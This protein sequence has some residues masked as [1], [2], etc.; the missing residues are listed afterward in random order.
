MER[1]YYKFIDLEEFEAV[2][3]DCREGKKGRYEVVL[4][5]T[6]FFP[7]GGGQPGDTGVLGQAQVL[8]THEKNGEVVHETDRP[9]A[10]GE[11]VKGVLD[12]EKRFD[13]MQGHS[14]EHILTGLI[15]KTF[16]FDNVGFHMGKEE[17]T[18]DF[19]GTMTMEQLKELEIKANQV[20]YENVPFVITCPSQ[21]ELE[22]MEYRSKKELTGEV[23]IVTIPEVDVC[24]CCGTHVE[25]SGEVGLIK[26]LGMI[27]YK[28]GVRISM[29]CG[30]PAF[31][32]LDGLQ[33]QMNAMSVLLSAKIG[34][35]EETVEKL[36]AENAEKDAQV[37]RA[38]QEIFAARAAALPESSKPLV[39]FEEGLTPVQIRQFSTLL[40]ESNKG[41]VAVVCSKKG[42]SFQYAAGSSSVDMRAFSKTLNGL[43]NG[44]GGGSSQMAQGTFQA[45]EEDIRKAVEENA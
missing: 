18:I 28:G 9:L 15:H 25:R 27:H 24:A 26:V 16:G 11:K 35:I 22:T 41:N 39:L 20:V 42:D 6:A 40:Y 4:D 8:D 43:L 33:K 1:L 31:Q 23:R 17:I 12:W 29:L 45:A 2:V 3:T 44:R 34:K 37:N 14:G 38:Y 30:R 13:N 32:Y 5:Q 19:N 7:E 21:E 36:K 10:V